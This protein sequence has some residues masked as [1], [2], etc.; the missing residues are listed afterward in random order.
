[1]TR[2]IPRRDDEME[3]NRETP[4]IEE[5]F[6]RLDELIARLE[7][8]SLS[9]EESFKAYAEGLSLVK[10]CRESIDEVEKKVLVLEKSGELHEL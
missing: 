3:E 5:S 2:Q 10:Q 7:E 8:D 4:T 9:L 6:S 1:M